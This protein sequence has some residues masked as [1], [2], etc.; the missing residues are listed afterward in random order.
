MSEY[1]Y[2]EFL[3]IDHSLDAGVQ[4]KLRS[5]SSRAEITATSFTNHYEWG[6]LKGDPHKF[7]EAWFDL[8]VYVANWGARRLMIRVPRPAL[9]P[10]DAEPFLSDIDWVAMSVSGDNVIVDIS[11]YE[12]DIDEWDDGSHW[13]AKLAPLRADL[14]CGDL[15][16]FYLIWLTAVEE[17]LISNEELEP[18]PGIGPLSGALESLG[19]FLLIDPDLLQAAAENAAAAGQSQDELRDAIGTISEHEKI[20]LLLRVVDGDAHVA[21][22]LKRRFRQKDAACVTQRTAGD[23]RARR[24]QVAAARE[25]ADAER[26]EAERRRQ[27]EHDKKAREVR[28]KALKQR[29]EAVWRE[30]E[31]EVERRNASGYDNAA[32]LLSDF[33]ALAG[34]QGTTAEFVRRIA[35]IRARHNTKRKFLE[36]LDDIQP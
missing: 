7:M 31:T 4:E 34:E 15:R 9:D 26:Q 32:A 25:R 33:K 20:Q 13:M 28:L 24:Q 18:L 6:D 8:H 21:S 30:I 11:R 23:L 12:L 27:A 35:D 22:E 5:I 2:Y 19:E 3:A 10:S 1:Q 36:R 29:G 16:L 14:L 17:E